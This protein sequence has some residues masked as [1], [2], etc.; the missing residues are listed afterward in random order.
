MCGLI[1]GTANVLQN[2]N[3]N[4][5]DYYPDDDQ[6]TIRLA[7]ESPRWLTGRS[8]VFCPVVQVGF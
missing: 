4:L 5:F 6:K 2:F 8:P 3:F 7:F 1:T